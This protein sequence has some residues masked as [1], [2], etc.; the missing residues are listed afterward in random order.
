MTEWI[1]ALFLNQFSR[2]ENCKRALME[3]EEL[4]T[5]KQTYLNRIEEIKREHVI[6]LEP[7]IARL[8][9]GESLLCAFLTTTQLILILLKCWKPLFACCLSDHVLKLV[10]GGCSKKFI[11][12]KK[13]VKRE[14]RRW[15]R[16]SRRCGH[17]CISWAPK[18][19]LMYSY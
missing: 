12:R 2:R 14:Q 18:P 4:Q 13:N 8:K 7:V 17:A 6:A 3:A 5:L 11:Q 15:I 1:F 19:F 16:V 9:V 10:E